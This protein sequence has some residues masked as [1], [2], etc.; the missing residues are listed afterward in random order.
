[1]PLVIDK[2]VR[3]ILST[4]TT[5]TDTYARSFLSSIGIK[6][7]YLEPDF[8]KF[9][10]FEK[11]DMHQHL[12]PGDHIAV[13][14][15]NRDSWHHG[16]YCG[17]NEVIELT[18]ENV[19]ARRP[20]QDFMKSDDGTI[21]IDFTDAISYSKDIDI[22]MPFF[23]ENAA[24]V[25]DYTGAFSKAVSLLFAE[26]AV[27]HVDTCPVKWPNC[28]TFALMCRTGKWMLPR[29]IIAH[30]RSPYNWIGFEPLVKYDFLQRI[31]EKKEAAKKTAKEQKE[32]DWKARRDR[33]KEMM[34]AGKKKALEK[35]EANRLIANENHI[36]MMLPTWKSKLDEV[37]DQR[38]NDDLLRF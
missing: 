1:M 16:I 13:W 3:K 6:K 10:E 29:D 35:M 14:E 12:E 30:N 22:D 4:K 11:Y 26:Y 5:E 37:I 19:I 15:N 36:K 34:E 21:V 17:N 32:Q 31:R 24:I 23:A 9:R 33:K 8:E 20:Y 18:P 7:Y 25:I 28:D 27:R 38:H 2:C